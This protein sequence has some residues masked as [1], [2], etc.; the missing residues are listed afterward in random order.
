MRWCL[1]DSTMEW[2]SFPTRARPLESLLLRLPFRRPPPSL[3]I[4]LIDQSVYGSS[5]WAPSPP[6]PC[7]RSRASASSALAPQASPPQSKPVS[8]SDKRCPRHQADCARYLLAERAFSRVNIFE[9]RSN[10]GG[11]WN[12]TRCD[13]DVV[14]SQ[15]VPQTSPH[16]ALPR[17]LRRHGFKEDGTSF[18]SPLY[19]RLET[20][21]P[22]GLMGFS[23]LDWPEDRPLFPTHDQV[24]EYV[25]AYGEE[26]KHLVSFSTQVVDVRQGDDGR[27]RVK[28]QRVLLEADSPVTE[29]SFDAVA[30]ASGHFDVPYIPPVPGIEAWN[31]AYPDVVSHSKFYRKPEDYKDKKVIVVGNSASGGDIGG[32]IATTCKAPL[33][34]SLDIDLCA[35][36][37]ETTVRLN[38]PRIE[39]FVLER[40]TVRFADGR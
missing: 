24:L 39:E 36:A 7:A 17:P 33:L 20:N 34:H 9:Q 28:T 32:Q 16:T 37:E 18:L 25:E 29:E 30:V 22:R 31:K 21:I 26:L 1:P 23:D 15:T 27:W 6:R 2:T 10:V 3:G 38:K 19:D 14:R 40:R 4:A 11:L 35:E 13:A 5:P 8:T 12:Y